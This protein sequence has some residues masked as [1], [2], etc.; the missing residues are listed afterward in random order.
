MK[1]QYYTYF[2]NSLGQKS[3]FEDKRDK[4]EILKEI[5]KEKIGYVYQGTEFAF[6]PVSCFEKENCILGK[7]GRKSLLK[8]NL[9]PE[10]EF[11]KTEE[12]NWPYCFVVFNFNPNNGVGQNVI[13]QVN[14]SV[15]SN[16]QSLLRK[17]SEEINTKLFNYDFAVSI[18]PKTKKEDFWNIVKRNKGEIEKVSLRFNAPNL[19]NLKNSLEDDLK[20]SSNNYA[21][22]KMSI[23]LENPNGGVKIS[24]QDEFIKQ[25]AEY[26][27]RG[28]GEYEFKLKGKK[29][30]INSK[31]NIV[32]KEFEEITEMNL[33]SN[34]KELI[35]SVIKSIIK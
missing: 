10:K 29:T 14:S 9:P 3:L 5:L 26:L 27:T 13:F 20:E 23:D 32:Q 15:F 31:K 7:I 24:D 12:E 25:S 17:F 34:D 6:V 21:A 22:T 33:E 16:P 30:K 11:E 8:R 2:I 28:G 18:N 35:L 4:N 19:F 1:F